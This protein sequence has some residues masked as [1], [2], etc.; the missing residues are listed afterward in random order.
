MKIVFDKSIGFI[1]ESK[2][3]IK[4]ASERLKTNKNGS[5]YSEVVLFGIPHTNSGVLEVALKIGR[6]K[7]DSSLDSITPKS[8]LTLSGHE[9]YNLIEFI[10]KYYSPMKEGFDSFIS[11]GD[12]DAFKLLEKYKS[13]DIDSKEKAKAIFDSGI[14]D[15]NVECAFTSLRRK[16]SLDEFEENIDADNDERFWQ[17]WFSKNKWFFGSD[18]SKILDERDI[19]V[20]HI[21]D[22]IAKSNDGF[23]EIIEIKKP[24][25]MNFWSSSPDHD[26]LV[27]SI[28]LVKAITQCEN[29]VYAIEQKINCIDFSERVDG[30][31]IVKP[32]CLLVFGRSSDW[33][34]KE[35]IAYR[36][37]NSSLNHVY[38]IT[39][40]LLLERAKINLGL[41]D[42]ENEGEN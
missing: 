31:R 32:K 7:S 36:L 16:R 22:Y 2:E 29:Y 27:P 21:A 13:L 10:K 12:S 17:E 4:S 28:A 9:F 19:D 1:F 14:L 23:V 20:N 5:G 24:N 18:F 37:L 8:E 34:D 30:V 6:Y 25:G 38:V 40:D 42:G 39:Y 41:F 15:E 26:N 3:G 33:T 11:L 35:K